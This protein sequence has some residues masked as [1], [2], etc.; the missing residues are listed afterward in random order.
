MRSVRPPLRA[1][2]RSCPAVSVT[3]RVSLAGSLLR[4]HCNVLALCHC[5]EQEVE[6]KKSS[7]GT[8]RV[9]AAKKK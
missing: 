1:L 2:G 9:K 6:K 8:K 3:T 5:H 7:G 4:T